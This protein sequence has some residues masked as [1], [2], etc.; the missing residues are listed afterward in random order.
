MIALLLAATLSAPASAEPST[1][2]FPE[3]CIFEAV[4]ARMGASVDPSLPLPE[5][6][7]KSKTSHEEF[8]A[9]FKREY[10]D[11]MWQVPAAV[12]N[13]YLPTRNRIYLDD[14][15][16]YRHGRSLTESAAHEYAHYV[17]WTYQGF[18]FGGDEDFLESQAVQLQFWFREAYIIPGLSPCSR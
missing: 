4:A 12:M 7:F 5:L 6:R 3:R 1:L 14:L 8:A 10:P 16:E 18:R 15:V 9:D 17:Q 2:I 13:I 11:P